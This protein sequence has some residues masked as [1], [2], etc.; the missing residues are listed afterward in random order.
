MAD[1]LR[2]MGKA[3]LTLYIFGTTLCLRRDM[4]HIREPIFR[5]WPG[6]PKSLQAGKSN[7]KV[8][9]ELVRTAARETI[10][11]PTRSRRLDIEIFFQAESLLRPDVDNVIK[12]V[13]DALKGIAY[14]DDSQV[15]SVRITALPSTEDGAY[16]I[17][18][19]VSEDVFNRLTQ[20]PPKAFLI[21][22]FEGHSIDCSFWAGICVL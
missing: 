19:P 5:I 3:S 20:H 1:S 21:N 15:R 14:E 4:I 17:T 2:R 7:L 13:L 10:P 18:G 9:K 8:Y 12:P 16:G 6:R 22:I 11:A